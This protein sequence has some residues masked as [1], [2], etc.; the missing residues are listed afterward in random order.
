MLWFAIADIERWLFRYA[1]SGK[2]NLRTDM[3]AL[4]LAVLW[5]CPSR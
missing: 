3:V 2:F 1:E 5:A 4:A